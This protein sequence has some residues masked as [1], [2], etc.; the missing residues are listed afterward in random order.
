MLLKLLSMAIYL[1]T[2]DFVLENGDLLVAGSSNARVGDWRDKNKTCVT[3]VVGSCIMGSLTGCG[4][5]AG[6]G[7]TVGS[8]PGVIIGCYLGSFVGEVGGTLM[9]YATFCNRE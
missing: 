3:G 9:G 7:G 1:E 8:V 4:V 5:G 6:I 2:V